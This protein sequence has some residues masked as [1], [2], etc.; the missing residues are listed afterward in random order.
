[1]DVGASGKGSLCHADANA[2]ASES[3]AQ[4]LYQQNERIWRQWTL[5]A[6]KRRSSIQTGR[7]RTPRHAT[8][9]LTCLIHDEGDFWLADVA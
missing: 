8:E 6:C 5:A 3:R 7:Q 2:I 1:M 9:Q 4:V